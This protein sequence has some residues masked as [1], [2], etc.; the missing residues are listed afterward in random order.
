MEV[1]PLQRVHIDRF[2]YIRDWLGYVNNPVYE[3][4]WLGGTI[5]GIQIS[6]GH[7]THLVRMST[8][9]CHWLD[10]ILSLLTIVGLH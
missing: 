2:P 10:N 3:S 7:W 9:F 5:P 8:P 6:V 4:V 1:F